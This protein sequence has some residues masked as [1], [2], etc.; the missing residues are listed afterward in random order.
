[1]LAKRSCCIGTKGG[2]FVEQTLL[3]SL[4]CQWRTEGI[5]PRVEVGEYVSPAAWNEL[6]QR[7]DVV[8][9]DTR[10]DYETVIGTFQ[11][12]V[13]PNTR[14]FKEFPEW[15]EKNLDPERDQAVAMFCTG[16]IRCE[17]AT[18]YL[19]QSGFKSVYHLQGGILQY[20]ED[21]EETES[22][23]EGECFVFDER[24]SVNHQLA[25]G[26]LE[27]CSGCGNPIHP[28]RPFELPHR[29]GCSFVR[30]HQAQEN[31]E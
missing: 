2:F 11:G 5:D 3:N 24:V 6:I 16:G 12:A 4:L 9:I 7:E 29:D 20:L 23:W 30:N 10:N 25:Q 15:V 19:L 22:L 8:L 26:E 18:S 28:E 31:S 14:H 27:L 13:E 1:M 17:K 21:I